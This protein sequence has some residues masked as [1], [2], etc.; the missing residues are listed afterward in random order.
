MRIAALDVTA[1]LL[2]EFVNASQYR[3]LLPRA[4]F[5]KENPL[6]EDTKVVRVLGTE[7]PGVIRLWLE[8]SAFAD[9]PDGQDPPQ[10]PQIIYQTVYGRTAEEVF[11]KFDDLRVLGTDTIE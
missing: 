7:C 10:V 11:E 6:P 1:E 5:V 4:F 2:V 8:S 9:I 3:G